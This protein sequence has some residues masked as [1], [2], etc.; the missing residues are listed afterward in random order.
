MSIPFGTIISL[1]SAIGFGGIA[2]AY[3]EFRFQHQKQ[4]QEDIHC[5]KRKRYGSILIQMLTIL[6]PEHLSKTQEFRPDLKTIE[7]V[8]EEVRIEMLHGLLFASDN[9]INAMAQFVQS[10][11]YSSYFKAVIAMR[12]DLWGEKTKI[13]EGDLEVF[14]KK[15]ES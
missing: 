5:L 8:K 4:V 15:L 3:L 13:E 14:G 7:D 12:K 1:I 6:S 10:P 11:N 9:V 2:G